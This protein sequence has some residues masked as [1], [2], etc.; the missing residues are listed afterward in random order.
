MEFTDLPR[1]PSTFGKVRRSLETVISPHFLKY[2]IR[3]QITMSLS[4]A[5]AGGALWGCLSRVKTAGTRWEKITPAART[6]VRMPER[7]SPREQFR[8]W[9]LSRPVTGSARAVGAAPCA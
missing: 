8:I 7:R 4:W 3:A 9:G 5:G 6:V 1:L 2:T